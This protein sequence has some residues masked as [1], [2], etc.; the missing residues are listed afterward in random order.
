MRRA[1]FVF[2][3]PALE[4]S[5][6]DDRRGR[7]LRQFAGG[8]FVR[9]MKAAFVFAAGAKD[10]CSKPGADQFSEAAPPDADSLRNGFRR[11]RWRGGATRQK[12]QR[13]KNDSYRF[14][15]AAIVRNKKRTQAVS[16][17]TCLRREFGHYFRE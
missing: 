3:R 9:T 10:F 12:N 14:E 6:G 5:P 15:H 16:R 11:W 13:A 17:A 8:R 7:G 2:G 1:D 4:R